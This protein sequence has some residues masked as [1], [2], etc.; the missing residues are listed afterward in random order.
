M[1]GRAYTQR[2]SISAYSRISTE[3]PL[4][5]VH[6]W[7]VRDNLEVPTILRLVPVAFAKIRDLLVGVTEKVLA[8]QLRQFEQDGVINRVVTGG[9]PPRMDYAG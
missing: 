9:V 4:R 5:W 7:Y 8:A 1:I 3:Q 6:L 2:D